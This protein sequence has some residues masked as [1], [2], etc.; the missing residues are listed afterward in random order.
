MEERIT[1]VK[2]AAIEKEPK[3]ELTDIEKKRIAEWKKKQ[4]E[5]EP[6]YSLEKMDV[7]S[8]STIHLKYNTQLQPEDSFKGYR[9]T[10]YAATGSSS[11]EWAQQLLCQITA[12]SFTMDEKFDHATLANA[13][14]QALISLKPQDEIEG[15]LCARLLMLHNQY[16][17]YMNRTTNPGQ[18]TQ[19]IDTN[20]NRST[21]L[22][23]LYNETLDAL[24]KYRRKGEQKV[25][26]QHV[27][28]N[29]GA[30]A[31]VTGQLNQGGGESTEKAKDEPHG[32]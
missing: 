18:T 31:V 25:T 24:N 15:M 11:E 17:S 2:N 8:K 23:R 12:S 28:I 32:S 1:S 19:G 6:S 30:Q 20:I 16:M 3:R 13:Y 10:L 22:M 7:D 26:V 27:N 4:S 14:L 29:S 5:C 21:K 9:S